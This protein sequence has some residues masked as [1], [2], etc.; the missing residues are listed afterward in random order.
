LKLKPAEKRDISFTLMDCDGVGDKGAQVEVETITGDVAPSPVVVNGDGGG[1]FTY[2]APRK[3]ATGQIRAAFTYLRG[4]EHPGNPEV[5]SIGVKIGADQLSFRTT[6]D[7]KIQEAELQHN[8]THHSEAVYTPYP[9]SGA[10]CTTAM[11]PGERCQFAIT[12][13][14]A[15]ATAKWPQGSHTASTSATGNAVEAELIRGANGGTLRLAGPSFAG[16]SPDQ[17]EEHYIGICVDQEWKPMQFDLS[18]Q[19]IEHFSSI[20]KTVSIS[21]P[22]G[23]NN[24]VGSGT[25]SLSGKP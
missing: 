7:V 4:S 10:N 9:G 22:M 13:L 1:K 6:V 12:T 3:D 8:E 14:H 21:S 16:M 15:S 17:D 20:Q 18:E 24:C 25:L 2:T 11:Q 19:E 23:V 5:D